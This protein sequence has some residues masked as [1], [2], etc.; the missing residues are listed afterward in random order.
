MVG[1]RDW[2][3]DLAISADGTT[4][5]ASDLSRCVKVWSTTEKK[6]L[7]EFKGFQAS[8]WTVTATAD[9]LIFGTHKGLRIWNT[10]SKGEAFFV[11][12]EKKENEPERLAIT[13][14]EPEIVIPREPEPEVRPPNPKIPEPKKDEPKKD[15][16]KKDEPKKDE[17]KKDEPKK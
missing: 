2:I 6:A 1:H 10:A 4:L 14:G 11:A 9:R 16:P 3:S 8:V 15:E 7:S 13:E 5:F 12:R 17:P